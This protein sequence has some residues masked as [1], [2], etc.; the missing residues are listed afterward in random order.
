MTRGFSTWCDNVFR[1]I[2][3]G[4]PYQIASFD[5]QMKQCVVTLCSHRPQASLTFAGG[6]MHWPWIQ[7]RTNCHREIT[8]VSL[9]IHGQELTRLQYSRSL[10]TLWIKIGWCVKNN[11]HL[12]GFVTCF[13]AVSKATSGWCV[14]PTYWWK[15]SR[16]L[17]RSSWLI[18]HDHRPFALSYDT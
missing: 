3:A 11:S 12:L 5:C 15:V 10:L 14:T 2:F 18:Q 13:F 8:L 1:P 9:G 4:I 17:E 6:N 16:T 7:L